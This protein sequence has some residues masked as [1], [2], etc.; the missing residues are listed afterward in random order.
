LF[1]KNDTFNCPCHNS[2]FA[3]NGLV[4][5]GPAARPL[6]FYEVK[7]TPEGDVLLNPGRK[8]IPPEAV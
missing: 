8:I 6:S 4:I 3:A 1:F 2:R 7:V 5:N